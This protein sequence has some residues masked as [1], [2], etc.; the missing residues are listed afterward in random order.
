MNIRE[1]YSE[2]RVYADRYDDRDTVQANL[3]D[4]YDRLAA[5]GESIPPRCW[6]YWQANT[7]C[8]TT[9]WLFE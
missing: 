8:H 4:S 9:C 5:F 6:R 1:M 2:R 3:I 7:A